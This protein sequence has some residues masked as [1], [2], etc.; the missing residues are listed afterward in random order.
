MTAH[1]ATM[2]LE[3]SAKTIEQAQA[4]AQDT[5]KHMFNQQ[6][7]ATA[8]SQLTENTFLVTL[9]CNQYQVQQAHE[10]YL[11]EYEM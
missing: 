3:V 2:N 5:N 7:T 4:I 10:K 9:G 6:A 8:I 1:I 11:S